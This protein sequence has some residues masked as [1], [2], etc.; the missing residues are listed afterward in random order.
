MIT[1][2]DWAR[3]TYTNGIYIWPYSSELWIS[4]KNF[5]IL[6]YSPNSLEL[7]QFTY[8]ICINGDQWLRKTE[9]L[10]TLVFLNPMTQVLKIYPMEK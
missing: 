10:K 3:T 7:N 1:L 2:H 6:F 8:I 9:K 4:V 5:V